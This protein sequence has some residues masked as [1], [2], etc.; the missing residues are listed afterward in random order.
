MATYRERLIEAAEKYQSI[1]CMG[2]DPVVDLIPLEGNPASVI[3]EFYSSILTEMKKRNV[4]PG[5]V[6]PN[7]AFFARYGFDTLR[8]LAE[9][10]QMFQEEGIPV[11]LDVK[12]GDIGKTAMAYADES[13]TVYNADAVTVAPY[14]GYDSV[15]PFAEGYTD[16]GVYVLVRTSN[17]TATDI[18]EIET[19][20]GKIYERV[21]RKVMEWDAG[22]LGMVVGATAPE[23]L[24]AIMDELLASSCEMP[25]LI[26]G[27]GAQGGDEREVLMALKKSS[28]PEIHRVNSSSGINYAYRSQH[29]TAYPEAA[30]KALAEMNDA[31]HLSV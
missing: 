8:V 28:Q 13:F 3:K 24:H 17:A 25:L 22:S 27:I 29:G 7:H 31:F 9:L 6:K 10:I 21:M 11:I 19:S 4:F 15:K 5:A 18:Q 1:V 23:Q 20:S 16:R 12:R 14:M 30:V 26:P 2:M